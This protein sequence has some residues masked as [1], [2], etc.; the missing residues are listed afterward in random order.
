MTGG[1]N[2]Q[3]LVEYVKLRMCMGVSDVIASPTKVYVQHDSALT[4]EDLAAIFSRLGCEAQVGV[5][6]REGESE[7]GLVR[8]RGESEGG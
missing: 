5:S 8:G 3:C 1:T 4:S 7:V 2:P 6:Q